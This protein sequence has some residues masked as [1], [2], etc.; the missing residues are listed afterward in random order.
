MYA[1]V[2]A[3]KQALAGS[4]DSR[5]F[6]AKVDVYAA[7]DTIP[8]A[9]IVELMKETPSHRQNNLQKH[10]EIQP[11][12]NGYSEVS[13]SAPKSTRRWRSWAQA[14][15]DAT[16]FAQKVEKQFGP[17]KKNTAFVDSVARKTYDTRAILALMT[18]HIQQNLV[19][20][21]KK[22]YRQKGGIPQG[23][24]LSSILCNYFYAD[25][26]SEHLA[27]L[28]S[29]DCLLLRL[30]DAFLL[31]TT[32][33]AK[34]TQFVRIMHGGLPD[35]GVQVSPGKS[36]VTFNL[37]LDGVPIPRVQPGQGFPYCGTR[38]DCRTLDITRD[39][40]QAKDGAVFNSLTVEFSR[41][42]GQNFRRK[43]LNAFKIQSHLL[44][45]DTS[46]NAPETAFRNIH[47]AFVETATKMWAYARCLPPAKQ[48]HPDLVVRTVQKNKKKT[49][50]LLT[51][52]AR[53]AKHPGY[54]C[55]VNKAQVSWIAF[56]AFLR[57]L[58]RKQSGLREVVGWLER[59]IDE[60]KE[61][62]D[63]GL[64]QAASL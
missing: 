14:V 34:A 57:V 27:F 58:R 64:P 28:Q 60:L 43:A 13:D 45:Y 25:L 52:R 12:D 42:P 5:F 17:G 46:H 63:L 56:H 4:T 59:E 20:I 44:F 18:S 9:A 51:S 62:K 32:D 41:H 1:R 37:V 16:T 29:D 50:A 21:G 47:A 33:R 36:L 3:F 19:K 7:F 30:I 48:P 49:F 26:E 2:K 40:T 39:R 23:S 10:V 35:Y 55:T 24:I 22:Y 11:N 31:I 53:K 15:G 61:R 6:F 38:L 54:E 8:Q